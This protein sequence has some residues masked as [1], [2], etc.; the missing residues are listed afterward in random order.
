MRT[1]PR[2]SVILVTL[3]LG[4]TLLPGVP[5][6]AAVRA[7]V[8]TVVASQTDDGAPENTLDG[9]TSTRWAAYGEGQWIRYDL[10]APRLVSQVAIAFY[11]GDQRRYRFDLQVSNDA[12]TW[13]T[14]FSGQS[15]GTSTVL[16]TF[17]LGVTARFVRYLGHGNSANAW[18]TLTRVEILPR[19]YVEAPVKYAS[20]S[21]S[22]DAYHA[23]RMAVDSNLATHWAAL[24][25]GET[26]RLDLGSPQLVG[27][28]EIAFLYGD[29]RRA[30]FTLETSAD[31]TSWL[32]V[33]D[34]ES[35]GTTTAPERFNF[36]DRIN[37]R[38]VR[39]TGYGNSAG[40]NWNSI[41]DI[42]VYVASYAG[43]RIYPGSD[44]RLVYPTYSNG[45]R[46]PDFS[47]A[48]YGGGGVAIPTLT[49]PARVYTVS[50]INGD[51]TAKLQAAID[52]VSAWP[53]QADGFRG[54]VQLQAG[55]Y[56]VAGALRITTSGVV[57][58]GMGDHATGTVIKDNATTQRVLLTIA[59]SG[60]RDPVTATETT[61]TDEYVPVG[62]RSLTVTD[63][64]GFAVGDPVIVKREPNA[65]W[66]DAIGMDD[67]DTTGGP[68]DTKDTV[69]VS[70][71]DTN[72]QVDD[73][74]PWTAAERT[75]EYER[76]IVAID[77]NR[78]TVDA[79]MVEAFQSQFGLGKVYRYSYP[80][81]ISHVGVEGIRAESR[82]TSGTDEAHASW[83]I[84]M[85]GVEHSW[86]RDV[87][88]KYYVQGTFV[89]RY[90]TR[91][92]TVQD[93]AST[94]HKSRYDIGRRR[95]AFSIREA[96]HM[97]VMRNYSST[98]R[99]DFS[100]HNNTPGPN[101]F[102]DNRAVASYSELGPHHRWATGTLY[103][104]VTHNSVSGDQ[105]IG[106]H[107]AGGRGSG[108]GWSGA[109]QVFYNCV[110]DTHKM[111]S[112]PYA[113]NWSIG[114]SALRTETD[115]DFPAEFD[116]YGGP[117]TPWSLYLTQLRER[118]GDQALRNIG[119]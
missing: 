73:D 58:R 117:V 107:N 94:D 43:R 66:I 110:G 99:H 51:D 92:V 5:A 39:F 103:D 53:L 112:P 69:N 20:A 118:L 30:R 59:G 10:N 95:Y 14:V 55:T 23:P 64:S 62:S 116:A 100:T 21:S 9:S 42:A 40:S 28:V 60:T 96:S 87:T 35:S 19:E 33:F 70:C 11:L 83:M 25:N 34:G 119:Y 41:T 82:Y 2:R 50:E 102:L 84:D 24:G 15:G 93:S 16:E 77:G 61:I 26:L 57:L 68:Y 97:L 27:H 29:A 108:H 115:G 63:A 13:T 113:H 80:G 31:A 75:M 67:C 44:G 106:V 17:P 105:V 49:D 86:V 89:A 46:I 12:R 6:Q 47:Y 22:Q 72:D 36:G 78:L 88:S 85:A 32:T 101:V 3:A 98:A 7:P 114:C 37:T 18:N 8:A 4:V 76:T 45:D 111:A 91:Y 79:P 48:G 71:I 74:K 38:Y 56:E 1:L 65:D 90:G 54:V 52:T 104:N 81:R 109:Y